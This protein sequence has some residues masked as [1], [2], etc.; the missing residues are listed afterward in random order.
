MCSVLR[1]E[2]S[3]VGQG[4]DWRGKVSWPS[5]LPAASP[6]ARQRAW[7]RAFCSVMTR[8]ELEEDEMKPER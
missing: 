6:S 4:D 8:F 2:I 7:P 3:I 5:R 1:R